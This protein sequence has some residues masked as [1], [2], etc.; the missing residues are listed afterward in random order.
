MTVEK[1]ERG[2][3]VAVLYSPGFGA[4]WFTWGQEVRKVFC[5]RLA[6]A[7]LGESGENPHQ[8]AEEEFPEEYQGGVRDLQVRWVP[9]GYRFEIEEYD[10]S[11]AVRVF[12]PDDGMVA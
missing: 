10:G 6:L 2:G 3:A 1:L 12:S 9:K 7:V 4:G 5:P 11:E 8:V